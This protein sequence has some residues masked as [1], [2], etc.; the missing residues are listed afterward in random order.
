MAVT[1]I[2]AVLGVIAVGTAWLATAGR[3]PRNRFFGIRLPST[4]RS[5]EAW[6]AGHRAG[7]SALATAGAGPL[8]VALVQAVES[9][10]RSPSAVLPL[11]GLGW[12]V[13]WVVVA[14]VRAN[15]AAR[16]TQSD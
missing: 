15:A 3:L 14:H 8:T 9:A 7:A 2:G 11:V 6:I 12:L 4:M 10:D 16:G 5:D 13:A 1:A